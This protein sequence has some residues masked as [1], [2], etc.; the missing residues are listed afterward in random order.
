MAVYVALLHSIVL[1]G[2]R[3]VVMSDLRAM[4]ESLGFSNVKTLVA[5]GNLVFEADE[6]PIGKIEAQ[7]EGG[8]AKVFGKPVDIIARDAETWRKLVAGNPFGDGD[9]GEVVVRVMRK[10]LDRPVIETLEKHRNGRERLAV[11][12]GDLW[13]DFGGKASETRLLSALTTRRLGIGT[14]R[15]WNTARGL[16]EMIGC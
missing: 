7:L 3:R 13:I 8:F 11:V 14:L 10:P 4:A 9:G 6:Q 16:A 15:N 2:G 5:S 12:D 1:G